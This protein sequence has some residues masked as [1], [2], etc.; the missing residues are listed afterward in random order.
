A[1]GTGGGERGAAAI[2]ADGV[3]VSGRGAAQ[4]FLRGLKPDD[5][6]EFRLESDPPVAPDT[7]VIGGG[8]TLVR[9]G[10]VVVSEDTEGF[11][12]DVVAGR[13]PRTA[14][15]I[16]G[17]RLLLVTVDGREPAISVGMS[18]LEV[19]ELMRE[20]GCTDAM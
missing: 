13:A 5:Q 2:P 6:L 16:Q 7:D 14:V 19:A 3:V 9:D 8:P 18:L 11:K 10:R 12:P 1:R 4:E 20:L 17:R 15:G